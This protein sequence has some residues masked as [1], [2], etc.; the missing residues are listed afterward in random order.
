MSGPES[1]PESAATPAASSEPSI[2]M[3]A[4]FQVLAPGRGLPLELHHLRFARVRTLS[5]GV[6]DVNEAGRHLGNYRPEDDPV[7]T[8]PKAW[9]SRVVTK[10]LDVGEPRERALES[11]DPFANS[12]TQL[13]LVI[14]DASGH[15]ARVA[16][17][18]RGEL[19][20]LLKLSHSGEG[21]AWVTDYKGNVVSGASVTIRQGQSRRHTTT[22]DAQGIA[23]L[24]SRQELALEYP[25]GAD[26]SN[27]YFRPLI[28]F[29]TKGGK[30]A[31]TSQNWTTGIEPW[32]FDIPSYYYYGQGSLVGSVN[33]ERGIYRPGHS[34]HVVGAVRKRDRDGK[35]SVPKGTALV[36]VLDPDYTSVASEHV[37]V[38]EF[39]TFRIEAALPVTARLGRY[40]IEATVGD[41]TLYSEFKV[42]K[43]RP[44]RFEVK[45]KEIEPIALGAASDITVET[46]ANYLYG[47][48]LA[49]GKINYDIAVRP[50]RSLDDEGF[51][52]GG[53]SD[54]AHDHGYGTADRD[55]TPIHSEEGEL[56]SGNHRFTLPIEAL[57]SG[58]HPESQR[59]ELLVSASVT[60][61]ASDTITGHRTV[62]LERS[63]HTT[64]IK[65]DSWVVDARNGWDIR[66]KSTGPGVIEGEPLTLELYR[67]EWISTGL[68]NGAGVRYAG[69]YE[70]RLVGTRSLK[71]A[72]TA[73]TVHLSLDKG[74]SYRARV[75]AGDGSSF[76]ET[77]VWAYGD[78]SHGR[79]DNQP[80]LGVHADRASY[81]PGQSAS[82]LIESPYESAT[83][84]VTLEQEG[85]LSAQVQQLRGAGTE[86]AVKLRQAHL[87][88][89]YANVSLV[90]RTEGAYNV[91]GSPLKSG[92]VALAVSPKKQRLTLQIEPAK[93]AAR[94][95]E[96]IPVDVKLTDES[97][98]PVR[99]EVTLWASDEGVLR[100]TGYQTPDVFS[101]IYRAHHLGVSTSSSLLRFTDLGYD[102]DGMGGDSAPGAD[103][104]AAFRSRF[105]ET[106]FFSGGVVT[107]MHG[108]A[109]FQLPLPDNITRWRIMATAADAGTRFGSAEVDLEVSKPVQ[110]APSL[111]RFLSVGDELL[112][113]VVVHNDRDRSGVAR[114]EFEADGANLSG[115]GQREL[116]VEAHSQTTLTF[117]VRAERAGRASFSASIEL[118][119]E[120]D[121]FRIDLPVLA[122]TEK[123]TTK[124]LDAVLQAEQSLDLTL[125]ADA[126]PDTAELTLESAPGEIAA[127]GAAL[128]SLLDYPHG[129]TE[130]TTSRLIPMAELSGLL[131]G[132]PVFE[133]L[134]HRT[135]M[136]DAV[137][138]LLGHQNASGG[139]GLWPESEAEEFLTAYALFGL[140]LAR[141]SGLD[142][143]ERAI[144]SAFGYL[145]QS[146]GDVD[147]YGYIGSDARR[148]FAA[149]VFTRQE[150]PLPSQLANLF[151]N[152]NEL[153]PFGRALLVTAEPKHPESDAVLQT[154]L[155]TNSRIGASAEWYPGNRRLQ[156]DAATVLALVAKGR[157]QVAKPYVDALLRARTGR[158]DFGATQD[159]LW[160][161]FA[162]NQYFKASPL[163]VL[164]ST[165]LTLAPK[166]ELENSATRVRTNVL[167]STRERPYAHAREPILDP[168]T[169]LTL[170]PE[171]GGGSGRLVARLTY[172]QRREAHQPAT[173]G[174]QV[175]R[176]LLD[177]ESLEPVSE[178]RVGQ[179][180]V[181]ELELLARSDTNQVALVDRL[182]AGLEAVD[183]ELHDAPGLPAA[184]NDYAWVYREAHDERVS[185]FSNWL[186]GTHHVVRYVARAT[187]PGTFV[188][189]PPR[190]EAMYQPDLY[191]VGPM[192][193]LVV[194]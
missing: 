189:P 107:D 167:A 76:A 59:L 71:A 120:R 58:A 125:P 32:E 83:A 121:G 155:G 57:V 188:H 78:D 116:R 23:K 134:S 10:T 97:G 15:A 54:S 128:D 86:I 28:A 84:L 41:T 35:L 168:E 75:F 170:S 7:D 85:V 81:E 163:T 192:G 45:V 92:Y 178:L 184:A 22:T 69:Q 43:Y 149:L 80:R 171:R 181:V 24:P 193:T 119:G 91:A 53:G 108:R 132:H 42:A 67:R 101:P 147:G 40:S 144:E 37:T 161:L 16:L 165:R 190:A 52:S 33:P 21:L 187:R 143:P 79:I 6:D 118:D 126:D 88:N 51:S 160:A 96:T 103:A 49:K 50:A 122:P 39:G 60:D 27:D 3:P 38:T 70:T 56:N 61:A 176:K 29:A 47:A 30:V 109:S 124:V 64:W 150:R 117:P 5:L 112:A 94:P 19:Q 110:V 74:G 111:P 114:V 77:S 12:K 177:L 102:D 90:P 130:Q 2:S 46:T 180:V 44:N 123:R 148:P 129:C 182:P 166:A 95:G 68:E 154:L 156:E 89:V 26:W 136:Q 93:K 1:M 82:L 13:A 18:Q 48:P 31:F 104:H 65:N 159:N 98:K 135:K 106:A 105:L 25:A 153:T 175:T 131:S 152:S 20:V 186:P 87:P 72:R 140:Q 158:G 99:G 173:S 133:S 142:V 8:L 191:G 62:S 172:H 164:P 14:L 127:L 100:L 151:G 146:D 63:R 36:R 157:P 138:H 113:G 137:V 66:V 141:E 115:P 4:G 145:S 55:A 73:Q 174:F 11:F 34:V 194:Q 185:F 17:V 183:L 162:L 179:L 9:R 169:R 139:F